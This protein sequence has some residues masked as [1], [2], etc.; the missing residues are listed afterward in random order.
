MFLALTCFAT[1]KKALGGKIIAASNGEQVNRI[2]SLA[3]SRK[4]SVDFSGYWQRDL[5]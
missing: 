1:L 4:P 2:V 5:G 3:M